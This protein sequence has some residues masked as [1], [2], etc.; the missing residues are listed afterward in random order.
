MQLPHALVYESAGVF[1]PA[2]FFSSLASAR[3]SCAQHR[4]SQADIGHLN[5]QNLPTIE[6][7]EGAAAKGELSVHIW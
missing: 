4:S 1:I 7:R 5:N 3:G 2:R 6:K